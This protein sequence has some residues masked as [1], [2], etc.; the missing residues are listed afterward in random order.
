[1]EPITYYAIVSALGG[2]GAFGYMLR[3]RDRYR[4][5]WKN[6]AGQSDIESAKRELFQ[7]AATAAGD[8]LRLSRQSN[9]A[10]AANA[11]DLTKQLTAEREY[12]TELTQQRDEAIMLS[13]K[14][15]QELDE[16]T[17][18]C[19]DLNARL[20]GINTATDLPK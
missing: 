12:I 19:A 18:K 3:Q 1:M 20:D 2:W 15:W 4:E 10:L 11:G 13:G 8:E 14:R 17:V 9:A 16:M 6:Q 7:M 5:A